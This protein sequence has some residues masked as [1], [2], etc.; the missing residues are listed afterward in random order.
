MTSLAR[1]VLR[2]LPAG[3]VVP[4]V[5]GP[6]RGC[7]WI[8]GAA[9]HGA[10]LGTLERPLLDQFVA[11]LTPAATVWDIGANVGLY[12]L[13]AAPRC[14]RVVA[15]E[16]L[17]RNVALLRRHLALNRVNNV[18]IVEAA[19]G[20]AT[21]RLRM[22]EGMTPSE[23]YVAADG[24]I[25][26]PAIALDTW[27]AARHEPRPDVVKIDVEGA[28]HD[29]LVGAQRSLGHR[30]LIQIALHGSDV[31]ARCLA[32]LQGAGYEVTAPGQADPAGAPEWMCR[33]QPR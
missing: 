33:P 32:W 6:L 18:E 15:F 29:V 23:A 1:R 10:W 12:S 9:P 11:S 30:P 21:G 27:A 14:R 8:I 24:N 13:A 20:R 25:E 19:V 28:E 3:T 7:R 22:R 26:V 2:L 16:P 5:A 4:V 17:P 31:A